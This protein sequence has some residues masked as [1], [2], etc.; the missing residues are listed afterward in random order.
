MPA[1][2]STFKTCQ[3]CFICG[4]RL[5]QNITMSS[6][7]SNT[8]CRWTITKMTSIDLCPENFFQ[9]ERQID[10]RD[11][12]LLW[13]KCGFFLFFSDLYLPVAAAG[14]QCREYRCICWEVYAL[15]HT[16]SGVQM[17]HCTCIELSLVHDV[18]E[19]TIHFG[20]KEDWRC[21]LCLSQ[22]DYFLLKHINNFIFL[23][24]AGHWSAPAGHR[25]NWPPICR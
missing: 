19:C 10:E 3:P 18:L 22:L 15:I 13:C 5:F 25:E 12:P 7:C 6:R 16:W 21:P 24:L 1:L 9:S 20:F 11:Q 23:E 4:S 14:V 17:A 8:N 2:R